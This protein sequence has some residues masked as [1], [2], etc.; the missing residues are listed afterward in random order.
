MT[1]PPGPDGGRLRVPAW[2]MILW[3]VGLF[4]GLALFANQLRIAWLAVQQ[5]DDLGEF[6]LGP[7][8]AAFVAAL[9]LSAFQMLAWRAI[10]R[11]LRVT[12]TLRETTEGFM[13]SFLPW[14]ILAP[15]GVT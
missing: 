13:I 2:R 6:S 1:T 11:Y 7:L 10:M 5:S 9:A 15:C 14:Y 12:L 8:I 4:L 3:R